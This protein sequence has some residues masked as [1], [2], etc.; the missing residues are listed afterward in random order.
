MIPFSTYRL[1]NGLRLLHYFDKN[2]QMVTLNLL[3]D[4][5]SKD[6]NPHATGLAHLFEHLM[7]TGSKHA[8]HF[9]DALQAAGGSSNA[10]TS[11]DFTNYYET[12]PAHNVET[13]FWLESDRLRHL[14]LSEENILT[15][16]RVVIEEFKQRCL[17]VPYG[18]TFHLMSALAYQVHPYR[19]PTIGLSTEDIENASHQEITHFFH[20]HYAV[21][22]LILC[23][24][25]HVSFEQAVSLCEKW[26]GDFQSVDLPPRNLPQE[27]AQTEP[28][29]QRVRRKVPHN[30]I[31]IMYHMCGRRHADYQAC[32]MI[33]DIL[34]NG[35]SSRFFRNVMIKQNLF[36]ELDAS[37]SGT[38]DPGL[39]LVKAQLADGVPFTKAQKAIDDEISDFLRTGTTAYE[40]EKCANKFE[41]TQLFSNIT[42]QKKAVK[43]CEYELLHQAA[44]INLEVQKYRNLS[45]DSLMNVAQK[46]FNPNNRSILFYGPDA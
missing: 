7:F 32:D 31:S 21:N 13:A 40:M 11:M 42:Y 33:S 43:L 17:N 4:V 19:W 22:N 10:W 37:I 45:E 1:K 6:E 12:L 41:S 15:Q 35:K 38:V 16:K 23:V 9:D 14:N 28:R 36:T 39:L 18:D 5:G 26:F 27:P 24:S 30:T 44:D 46:L 3:Y 20:R 8:P 25:G 29:F 34:L 2:T